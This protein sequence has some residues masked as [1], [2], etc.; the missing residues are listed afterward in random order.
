MSNMMSKKQEVREALIELL[1]EP[2]IGCMDWSLGV[3]ILNQWREQLPNQILMRLD[4]LGCV[5]KVEEQLPNKDGCVWVS[6]E[7]Y[8]ANCPLLKAG[9]CQTERLI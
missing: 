1:K 7:L 6:P 9:Y 8:H 3:S 5:L 4:S 2:S